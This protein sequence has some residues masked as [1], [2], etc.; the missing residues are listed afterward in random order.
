MS[1]VPGYC[2]E[3]AACIELIVTPTKLLGVSSGHS[4]SRQLN[5]GWLSGQELFNGSTRTVRR[6][7]GNYYVSE[8]RVAWRER[9]DPSHEARI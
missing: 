2:G 3:W 4:N 5:K 9:D 8:L 6:D 1:N 7:I